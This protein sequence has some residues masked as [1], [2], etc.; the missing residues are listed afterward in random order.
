MRRVRLAGV[1]LGLHAY[2]AHGLTAAEYKQRH[3]LR[4]SRGLV[5]AATREAIRASATTQYPSRVKLRALRDPAAATQARLQLALPVAAE[6][7][8][9][10][11]QRMAQLAR[12]ARLGTVVVCA[13][14]AAEFCP[15]TSARRRRFCS[16]SCASKVQP[17]V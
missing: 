13:H 8:V 16:R 7:A 4:R 9:E 17:H 14:C 3:G 2:R 1:H 11:D 10:R 5:A 6:A 12:S 15:L